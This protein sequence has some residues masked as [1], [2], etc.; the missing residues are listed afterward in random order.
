MLLLFASIAL[1]SAPVV[2][3]VPVTVADNRVVPGSSLVTATTI[4]LCHC[5]SDCWDFRTSAVFCCS[6]LILLLVYMFLLVFLSVLF[7]LLLLL[8]LLL[9]ILLLLL[10]LL[11]L[12]PL[13]S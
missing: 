8:F 1:P 2:A 6:S 13:L 7:E 9:L 12:I 5:C 10:V 3:A 4:A 11:F